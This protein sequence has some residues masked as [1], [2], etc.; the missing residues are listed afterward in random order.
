MHD[1]KVSNMSTNG[2]TSP[3]KTTSLK[4]TSRPK[5][6]S[7]DVRASTGA[8]EGAAQKADTAKQADMNTHGS[9]T[10]QA[11]AGMG[12]D[13]AKQEHTTKQERLNTCEMNA[14]LTNPKEDIHALNELE[15]KLFALRYA[16]A[17]IVGLG[18]AIDPEGA[19]DVRS[20]VLG[21]MEKNRQELLC[22]RETRDLLQRLSCPSAVLNPT[23][24]AQLRV[25]IK[26]HDKLKS[27]SPARA[28]A[29]AKL[30]AQADTAWHKAKRENSWELFAPYLK[31]VI[32]SMKEIAH[33]R[34]AVV[35][36]FSLWCD[37]YEP[38]SSKE[39]L[40]EFFGELKKG[41]IPLLKPIYEAAHKGFRP[42]P[43]IFEGRFDEQRQWAL[44]RDLLELE[45]LDTKHVLLVP[46][47][48]PY[49][50]A[51]SSHYAIIA[52]HIHEDNVLSNVFSMFHE[53]GHSLYEMGVDPA[54]DRTSLQ[55]GTSYGMH[56]AQSRFFEN[57]VARDLHFAPHILRLMQ[58]HFQGQ[59]GR[60]TPRQFWSISNAVVPGEIRMEAD[61]LTYPL[62][63]IVRYEIE[64]ALFSGELSVDDVPKRWAE[65]YKNYLGV[66]VTDA[67]HGPLQDMHWSSGY[68][69][70]FPGYALGSAY[71][72]QFKH[73]MIAAGIDWD[74]D[75]E[76][77]DTSRI[78]RWM[79]DNIWR[80]GRAKSSAE[81]I[82]D[83]CG[84]EFKVAYYLEYLTEKFS[85]L[86]NL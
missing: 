1:E 40:D 12:A 59:L 51:P 75:L 62:H 67:A 65:L 37:E 36:P 42:K 16:N 30:I 64:K 72:A 31:Q 63:I 52:T 9:A 35:D 7:T 24:K 38:G 80:F 19:A 34:N 10:P 15:D 73:A 86:Y 53:G 44:A 61:E 54:Y 81:L 28:Q 47:E 5:P 79:G 77:G 17:E 25:L 21:I 32:E 50:C 33:E 2:N 18:M 60:V 49:S 70:Y 74:G 45:G 8:Q 78:R 41:I 84:E 46:T 14:A 85:K 69:G 66:T 43:E 48:H 11:G 4:E 39:S 83:A 76:K 22:S 13:T 57:Y 6:E 58:K 27:V 71:G 23:Q 3:Q 55:G 26:E 29:H 68:I 20:D 82:R 56:E